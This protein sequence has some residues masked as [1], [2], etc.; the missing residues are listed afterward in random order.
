MYVI[1]KCELW[2][3]FSRQGQLYA[4][5][6]TGRCNTGLKFLRWRLIL[7]G[8]SGALV[9]LARSRAKFGLTEARYIGAFR[10]VLPEKA[11]VGACVASVVWA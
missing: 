4:V 10:E 2:P 11:V 1:G 7:Q 9:K 6:S 5:V 3:E 8:L